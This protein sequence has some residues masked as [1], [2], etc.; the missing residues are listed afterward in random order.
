MHSRRLIIS[1]AIAAALLAPQL[2]FAQTTENKF[3]KDNPYTQLIPQPQT[4]NYNLNVRPF[5]L[6]ENTVILTDEP[7]EPF[8]ADY[9][10]SKLSNLL[11]KK[12]KVVNL[13]EMV[14]TNLKKTNY[15]V[16]RHMIHHDDRINPLQFK[17][18]YYYLKVYHN[19]LLITGFDNHGL[20]NGVHTLL[21]LLPPKVYNVENRDFIKKCNIP[22]GVIDDAPEFSY[23][24]FELD[25]SR[26]WRPAEDVYKVLD[27][28]AYHKLNKF[29]WHL[30]DDQGWRIEIKALPLLTEKGAWRGPD[31]VIPSSFGSGNKRY[32]GFYTQQQIKDIVKYAA[33]RGIEIIPEVETPGHSHAIAG[34]YPEILCEFPEDTS[35]NETGFSREIWCVAKEHNYEIIEMIIKEMAELLPSIWEEM[36]SIALTGR[37]ARTVRHL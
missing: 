13:N 17:E 5:V 11:G 21:Q 16:I 34:S 10:N 3:N 18:G 14:E 36:K 33:D 22:Q 28:M 25:V 9:L 8:V 7:N 27:W 6:T 1:I 35:I 12:I 19:I 20:L 2:L 32:G 37:N 24:G 30:T 23:R 15:I 4:V 29:H 31:E 26:T